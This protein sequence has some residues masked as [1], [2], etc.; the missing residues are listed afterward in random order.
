MADTPPSDTPDIESPCRKV[1]LLDRT[2]RGC[3]R[4]LDEIAAWPTADRASKL[5]ILARARDRLT[6]H[7]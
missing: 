7:R 2:C 5:A 4:T 3:G 6:P 1:C